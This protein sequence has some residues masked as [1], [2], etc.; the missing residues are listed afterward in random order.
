M[1]QMGTTPVGPTRVELRRRAAV[2]SY[3]AVPWLNNP[4]PDDEAALEDFLVEDCTLA[5]G[6]DGQSRWVIAEDVRERTIESATTPQLRAAWNAVA[7]RP[8]DATQWALD[9][10]VIGS[11]STPP[12]ADL[13]AE[14]VRA[15]ATV[16]RW[17]SAA[18]GQ[19][20]PGP[21][22]RYQVRL[23]AF[24]EPLR[25]R[26]GD[27]FVGRRA[28][29]EQLDSQLLRTDSDPVTLI[30]GI[31]GIGKSALVAKHLLDSMERRQARGVYLNFDDPALDARV[32][33][34]LLDRMASQLAAQVD[35]GQRAQA[36]RLAVEA[37][38][39]ARLGDRGLEVSSRG[40]QV[41]SLEWIDLAHAVVAVAA[42]SRRRPLLVVVD[43]FEQ[44]QRREIDA[45]HMLKSFLAELS[46]GD[47]VHT[48]VVVGQLP[49]PAHI[50]TVVAGRAPEPILVEHPVRLDGLARDEATKL[51]RRLV[52]TV[53]DELAER[54]M[55]QLGTSPLTLRLVAATLQRSGGLDD[56]LLDLK[57]WEGRIDGELYRRLLHQIKDKEVQKL[58]HP[59][60]TVRRITPAIIQR[61]LAGPCGVRVKD[62]AHAVSLFYRLSQ[63]AMLVEWSDDQRAL[64]HRPDVRALMLDQ[65]EADRKDDVKRIHRAA[66]RYYRS[67]DDLTSRTE[68]LYHRL[69]LDQSARTLNTRWIDAASGPLALAI[70][71]LPP[72][73]KA[74]LAARHGDLR[75]D[76]ED[77]R[78]AED[79]S[80]AANVRSRVQRL[81]AAGRL[82][83]AYQLLRG[84]AHRGRRLAVARAGDRGPRADG[85]AEGGRRCR[86]CRPASRRPEGSL[87]RVRQ[88]QP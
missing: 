82:D 76:Q 2:L 3:F 18:G 7:E 84:P 16:S 19:P 86:P 11:G 55:G 70:D 50:H 22:L 63:V 15:V 14:Q 47:H 79:A 13:E 30:H 53:P 31:G 33:A 57:L 65:L 51:L 74:Y 5:T 44:V 69:M 37:R 39:L 20:G 45:V 46:S 36:E 83:E 56:D 28:L 10:L 61:V 58:A 1:S 59:G 66:V 81:V 25:V 68:E 52:P 6:P 80:W 9:K 67:L 26:V 12:L 87:L 78:E 21:D 77:L 62:E 43:T 88:V 48:T 38:D 27:H 41:G 8:S 24:V 32:P 54:V 29:L 64:I 49:E 35:P 75:L 17:L 23:H 34:T 40:V 71:E 73:A 60:L 72:R 85:T 42:P 4:H